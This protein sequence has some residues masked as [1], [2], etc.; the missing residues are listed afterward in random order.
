M[1]SKTYEISFLGEAVPAIAKAFDEFDVIVCS[2]R[3]TL[4][5]Q[6]P[7]QAALHG[8]IDR[9]RNLG[10]ELLEL[11]IVDPEGRGTPT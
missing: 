2:G 10:L 7:D 11:R 6:L 4:R 3:T 1:T 8:V 9:V 5:C